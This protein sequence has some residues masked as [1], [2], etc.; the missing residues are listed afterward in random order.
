MVERRAAHDVVEAPIKLRLL[1]G[2]EFLGKETDRE[3]KNGA[4]RE[5]HVFQC[6][7]QSRKLLD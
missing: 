7:P 6:I 2:K 4:R 1:L 3:R 5:G